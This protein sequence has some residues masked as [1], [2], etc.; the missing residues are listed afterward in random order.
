MGDI[1]GPCTSWVTPAC[2]FGVL[3]LCAQGQKA[4][5]TGLSGGGP[6]PLPM[7][8]LGNIDPMGGFQETSN[9]RVWC[10]MF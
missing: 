7:D 5:R 1:S 2:G 3:H 4:E 8:A 10:G 6:P 9:S